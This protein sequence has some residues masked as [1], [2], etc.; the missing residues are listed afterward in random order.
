[1]VISNE[2]RKRKNAEKS[3]EYRKT[4]K[5]NPE[6]HR[7]RSKRYYDRHFRVTPRDKPLSDSKPLYNKTPRNKPKYQCSSS[8]TPIDLIALKR[9]ILTHYGGGKC[10]CVKCGESDIDCLS[11]DHINNDAHHRQHGG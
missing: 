7:L 2:E 10:A 1:M 6:L 4:H 3:R 8:R 5:P 11:I 9:G